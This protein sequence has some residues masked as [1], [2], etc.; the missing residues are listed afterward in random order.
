[1]R[2]RR[3]CGRGPRAGRDD[4]EHL[5]PATG[6]R[7]G[8]GEVYVPRL[9]LREEQADLLASATTH[10]DAPGN[11]V[12]AALRARRDCFPIER[13][14]ERAN[15]AGRVLTRITKSREE[16]SPASWLFAA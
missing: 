3:W 9:V 14:I 1:M 2:R 7:F 4:A 16:G 5:R 15:L 13:F 6:P 12:R 10:A 11:L 8:H